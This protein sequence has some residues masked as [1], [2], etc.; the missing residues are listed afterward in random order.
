MLHQPP[1]IFIHC[2]STFPKRQMLRIISVL[3]RHHRESCVSKSNVASKARP[4][5]QT[6]ALFKQTSSTIGLQSRLQNSPRKWT[7]GALIYLLIG[8]SYQGGLFLPQ[9]QQ[10]VSSEYWEGYQLWYI[11]LDYNVSQTTTWSFLREQISWWVLVAFTLSCFVDGP[12]PVSWY[13]RHMV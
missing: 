12:Y 11:T 8:G 4:V 2:Q 9:E 5:N 10:R 13:S 1:L 3:C 6:G 7:E